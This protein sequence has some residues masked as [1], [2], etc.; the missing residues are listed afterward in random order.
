LVFANVATLVSFRTTDSKSAKLLASH[1]TVK[2]EK[3][4]NKGL[5]SKFSAVAKFSREPASTQF[6]ALPYFKGM[7]DSVTK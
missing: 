4:L 3:A 1:L 7:E 2:D 5:Q 6:E